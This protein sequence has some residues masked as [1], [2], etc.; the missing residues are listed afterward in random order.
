MLAKRLPAPERRRQVAA[1]ALEILSTDGVRGLTARAIAERVGVKDGSLFR[2]F[3]SKEAIV[4][5]AIDAFEAL[6]GETFP[7]PGQGPLAALAELF[8][9]RV[10]LAR[11]RP[12]LLRLALS[13]RLTEVA[14]ARGAARVH[15]VVERSVTFIRE[16]LTL[17]RRQGLVR[18]DVPVEV[19]VW[20]VTGVL[21][22]AAGASHA[23]SLR[24]KAARFDPAAAWRS[25]ELLLTQRTDGN[26]PK[27]R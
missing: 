3:A 16:Q 22:G 15:A 26:S 2:H 12:E 11:A 25:L 9:R 20:T 5:A 24:R 13:D 27:T 23:P 7:E 1:T 18:D 14:G 17:A 4:D 6:M 8:H 10:T 21:R 19:L